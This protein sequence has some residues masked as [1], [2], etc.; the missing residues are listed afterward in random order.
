MNNW[1]IL[2][3]GDKIGIFQDFFFIDSFENCKGFRKIKLKTNDP[4][5]FLAEIHYY[6][7]NEIYFKIKR[8]I[9]IKIQGKGFTYNN[10]K[11]QIIN[12]KKTEIFR[13]GNW[14]L[15]TVLSLNKLNSGKEINQKIKVIKNEMNDFILYDYEKIEI[16]KMIFNP[17]EKFTKDEEPI[18]KRIKIKFKEPIG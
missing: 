9:D 1:Q 16:N 8:K 4:D 17:I 3:E 13:D 14:N 7:E 10:N 12:E 2:K 5:I 15:Q 18:V 11:Y 6:N